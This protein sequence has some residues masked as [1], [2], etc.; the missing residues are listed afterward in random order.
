LANVRADVDAVDSSVVETR[1]GELIGYE[2]FKHGKDSKIYV[3]VNIGSM[4]LSIIIG[5]GKRALFQRACRDCMGLEGMPSEL[6]AISAYCTE[7]I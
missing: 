5:S 6:Y 3:C 1:K 7:S 4:L 2:E